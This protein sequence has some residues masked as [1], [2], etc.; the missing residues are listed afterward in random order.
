MILKI[1]EAN[2]DDLVVL[3]EYEQEVIKAERPMDPTI[4][5]EKVTYY[6]LEAL[7]SNPRAIII[8]ACDQEKIVG[9][10][11]ALEKPA[12]PY[13]DHTHYAYLGFMYTHPSYRG[14]GVNGKIMNR[15]SQWASTNGLSELRL[16]VYS[17]NQPAL[18]AY[19]KVGFN[20]H[21][22]EMRLRTKE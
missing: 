4:K 12:R 8:V 22:I 10:G 9:T 11:Y 1:R 3:R 16:T 15:L 7:M 17:G 5:N 18:R 20:N 6:D 2:L 21:M 13:L 19:E 14:K